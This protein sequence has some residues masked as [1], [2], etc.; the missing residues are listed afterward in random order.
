SAA[1][2]GG[3]E[4]HGNRYWIYCD[5]VHARVFRDGVDI[6]C[7]GCGGIYCDGPSIIRD[8]LRG[9]FCDAGFGLF[10]GCS[11]VLEA[12]LAF[13]LCGGV[14]EGWAGLSAPVPGVADDA[15]WGVHYLRPS[16]SISSFRRRSSALPS[17]LFRR[18]P[19]ASNA[20]LLT[21]FRVP[22]SSSIMYVFP[23]L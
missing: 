12:L 6:F 16:A 19:S 22:R 7:D 17:S 18:R 21:R 14:C 2:F 1:W 3:R 8:G 5:G 13:F 4:R 10:E 20:A 9:I 15:A 23:G 11:V